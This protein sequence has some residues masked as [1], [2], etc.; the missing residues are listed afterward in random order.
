MDNKTILVRDLP[1]DVYEKLVKM[2][3]EENRSVVQQI[4]HLIQ[5]G[6]K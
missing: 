4:R 2:A 5:K 3:K 1:R 6:V